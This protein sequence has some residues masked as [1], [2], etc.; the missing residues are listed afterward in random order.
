[1]ESN[2]T[3]RQ[4]P[5][6]SMGDDLSFGLMFENHAAIM[7]LI[8]PET[9]LILDAN[10]AAVKF[11]GYPKLKLRGM[12]VAEINCLSAEQVAVER[13]KAKNEGRNYIVMTQL[14]SNGQ[15]RTVEELS[16]NLVWQGKPVLFLIMHDITGSTQQH[17]N[18]NLVL[19]E[20]ARRREIILEDLRI[21]KIELEMQNLELCRSQ[22]QL[23][24]LS[25]RYFDLYDLA[26]VG[27]CT[28]SSEDVI[29]ETNLTATRL[30][31]VTRVDMLKK[32]FHRFIYADQQPASQDAL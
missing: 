1:M 22:E 6:I 24:A 20:A 31:G 12:P 23:E 8:E 9:G 15:E 2:K 32:P 11:Y 28:V 10:P 7:L 13:E 4:E 18:T 19:E 5:P 27:Y 26:P 21:H 17:I 25:A 30:F 14:L 3:N 29:I 16:S